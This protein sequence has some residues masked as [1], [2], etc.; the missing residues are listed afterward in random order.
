MMRLQFSMLLLCIL[1]IARV[2]LSAPVHAQAL[3][4]TAGETLTGQKLV[5]A[6]SVRNHPS[7]LIVS[8]SKEAG[9]AAGQWDKAVRGDAAL[10]GVGIYDAAI[11][12]RA[13]GFVR[14][15]IKSALRKQ[16]PSAVQPSFVVLTQEEAQWRSYFAVTSDNEPY[17]VL[18]DA[19]GQILWHGHGAPQDLEPQMRAAFH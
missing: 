17:V 13:P 3:P 1:P 19:S 4:S 14:G 9:T 7:V 5:L 8:F 12:E 10:A 6:D 2:G 16:V 11:I 18:L 15:M